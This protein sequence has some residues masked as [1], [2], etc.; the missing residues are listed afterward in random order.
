MTLQPI[1]RALRHALA[2]LALAFLAATAASAQ[3]LTV[4][5]WNVE[6]GGSDDQTIRGR[7]ASFQGVDLWGLSEVASPTAAGVF[8]LGAEDGEDADF[9]RVVGTT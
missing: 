5:S 2:F 3:T 1:S 6:S 8:E 4:V 9:G 7:M